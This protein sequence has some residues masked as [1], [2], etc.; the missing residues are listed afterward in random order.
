MAWGKGV[1]DYVRANAS[2]IFLVEVD[3]IEGGIQEEL[4]LPAPGLQ[5]TGFDP[6]L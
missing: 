3:S 1:I 4:Q 6:D 5:D 2:I